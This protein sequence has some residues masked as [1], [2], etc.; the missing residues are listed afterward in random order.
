MKKRYVKLLSLLV[1]TTLIAVSASNVVS[2]PGTGSSGTETSSEKSSEV[3]ASQKKDGE[4]DPSA[5]DKAGAALPS[6]EETVYVMSD[7]TGKVQKVIVSDLLKNPNGEDTLKDRTI[8]SDIVN[9]EG[10]ESFAGNGDEKLWS[11]N[12]NDIHYQGTVKKDPPVSVNVTYSLN[13]DPVSPYELAGK[14]GHVTIRFDYESREKTTVT[15]NGKEE[16]MAVPFTVITGVVLDNGTF[17]DIEVKGGRLVNDGTR[18]VAVGTAFPGLAEDLG[19]DKDSLPIPDHFE[20]SADTTG[21]RLGMTLTAASNELIGDLDTGKLNDLGDLP[22]KIGELADAADKLTDGSSEL[23]NGLSAL[24]THSAEL[25]DGTKKLADGASSLADGIA[26]ADNGTEKLKKGASDLS[27]GLKTLSANNDALTGGAKK[28]F[29]SLL[30][31]AADQ[32]KANGLSVP[33]MTKDNYA[34]VLGSVIS[35]LD[36]KN[37]YQK[38]L[39]EVTKAVESKRSFIRDQVTSSVRGEIEKGVAGAVRASVY[40]KVILS[41]TGMDTE[42]FANAV[43]AG[44]IDEATVAAIDSATDMQMQTD[45]VKGIIAAQVSAQLET[46]DIKAL[47]ETTTEGQIQKLISENMAGEEVQKKLAAASEG[48]KKV[49]SLKTSLDSYNAFYL[50]LCDYT[51]GVAKASA[52]ASDLSKG[53]ASLKNG[54][55]ELADGSR[56]LSDGLGSLNDSLPALI[57][58]ITKL[59]DGSGELADGMTKFNDTGIKKLSDIAKG[60]LASV[61]ARAK[62]AIEISRGYRNFSG[63]SGQMNGSVKFIYRTEEIVG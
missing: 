13:G 28:V 2:A 41:A 15:V 39:Q 4:N 9:T 23:Y 52:G 42:S 63:I 40:E 6:K 60:D 55:A 21:I 26:K 30:S 29:D 1:G 7:A 5:A 8:L 10:D 31:T 51:S 59:R 17:T 62:A 48:A 34:T 35:S 33:A 19:L 22:G 54:T 18:T 61:P 43:S 53:I 49:I 32:L 20:I 56:K 58:G 38:A 24:L 36:E 25:T 14:S 44:L 12:G 50:G 46:D 3:V 57:D 37:V 16:T 45:E 27:N 11:A 47:I